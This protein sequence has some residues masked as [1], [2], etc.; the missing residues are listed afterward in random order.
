MAEAMQTS[1]PLHLAFCV[2][3]CLLG[4]L[5]VIQ[6]GIRSWN[7]HR[8]IIRIL[9]T[10]FQRACMRTREWLPKAE[11][12]SAPPSIHPLEV[13]YR[14][15]HTCNLVSGGHSQ[16]IGHQAEQE[17]CTTLYLT[18]T[19]HILSALD[20]SRLQSLSISQPC[21]RFTIVLT[22]PIGKY[23]FL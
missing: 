10:C 15:V 16:T 8:C 23:G 14:R 21:H 22:R 18:H 9:E 17:R 3:I 13:R 12:G 5:N 6:C 19:R 11:L 7:Y 20:L 2:G 1:A 4:L